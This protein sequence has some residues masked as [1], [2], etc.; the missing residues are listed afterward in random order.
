[1]TP[2]NNNKRKL[3]AG[4]VL[5]AAALV[6]IITR[7]GF[8][9]KAVIPIPG[10][11]PTIGYGSTFNNMGLPVKMGDTI[12]RT[13]ALELAKNSIENTYSAG[14]KKCASD[15]LLTQY[16]FD[17]LVDTAYNIGVKAVCKSS[18]IT[19]FRQG[20]S[21]GAC[22]MILQYKYVNGK[23]CT[24]KANK[25]GGIPKDRLRAFHMCRGDLAD[26]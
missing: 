1:M 9:E 26:D 22:S 13:A 16:E 8:T 24:I 18:M 3:I 7:E 25:C 20:D 19:K 17:F 15:L 10:D 11:R 14:I 5:S 21:L 2:Q 6:G 4:I 12:T 23:D